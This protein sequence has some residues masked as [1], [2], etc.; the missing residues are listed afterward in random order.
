MPTAHLS[1]FDFSLIYSLILLSIFPNCVFIGYT[2]SEMI[3]Y[4]VLIEIRSKIFEARSEVVTVINFCGKWFQTFLRLFST[5]HAEF[6]IK[7]KD[8]A[9]SLWKCAFG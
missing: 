7:P 2:F 3:Q 4:R 8:P 6:L 9:R 1:L 5:N